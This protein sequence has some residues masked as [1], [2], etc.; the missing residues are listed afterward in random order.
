MAVFHAELQRITLRPLN[1]A[2]R[3]RR[4]GAQVH[5]W[6]RRRQELTSGHGGEGGGGSGV[7]P[8]GQQRAVPPNEVREII[9][10]QAKHTA[11][12]E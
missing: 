2:E 3:A 11:V 5:D 6:C 8:Y 4:R 12:R 9:R 7:D 1:R 10:A